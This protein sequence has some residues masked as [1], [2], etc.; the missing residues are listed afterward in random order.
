VV[1]PNGTSSVT[2]LLVPESFRRQG[3][4]RSL[5]E[6][7]QELYPNLGGQVSSKYAAKSAYDLGRRPPDNPKASLEEVFNA[8]D[9]DSS[10]NLVS[11]NQEKLFMPASEAGAGKGKQAEAAKLWNEK[12]TDSPYFKKWFG[13]SKVVDDNGEPLVVYHGTKGRFNEFE[14]SRGGEFGSGMY[15]S[16]NIDSAKMFGGFQAGD[17]EVVTMPAYLTLKNP[18]ITSDRNIP[19]GAGVKSL[20]KKGYDGVIGTTPN[21]QKQ[22]IAFSPEQ[23][24]SATGNRGTFDAG[25]R[26]ILFMPA[27]EAK[28]PKSGDMLTLDDKSLKLFLPSP[29][30]PNASLSE[31]KGKNVQ[32][33]TADLSVVGDKKADGVM[34]SFTGGPGYLSVNDAWGFTNEGGAKAFKTRWE[35]DGK[36]LIG[37]TSM[38]QEN[39][40]AST[41][42]REYYVR[43]FMEAINDGKI[44][45]NTVNRHIKTALKRAIDGKNGLTNN[46]KAALKTV[47]TI[48]DFL[49]V[50]PDK[51]LIPWK[52][53]PM[54]YGKLDAKTLPIKQDRLKKLGLDTETI[55]RETRQPEY[56]DI[57]KGSLLAIAEYDGSGATYRPDLNSAYPW[58]IPLNEKAFLKDFADIQD[59]SSRPDLRGSD[60]EANMAVAMGAGVMLDKLGRGDVNFMPSDP[61]APKAQPANR[62]QQQAPAMPGNRFMAPAASAGAKLSE[63]FR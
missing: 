6:K 8:I 58:S 7:A 39:H 18:L 19:R 16:E 29:S 4:G 31:F 40:R 53:T 56:N 34:I 59:L 61:K 43:K 10:V 47:K 12:G 57:K 20:I 28:N 5:Q 60:G 50:F 1:K 63:R 54:I 35:R 32:V 3:I 17:S 33:L 37:I 9:Q 21:G 26:N 52:A 2:Q 22:Y 62:I 42:T 49:K 30:N 13:K 23:I 24:K 38:K 11:Q 36:P 25:E 46:Q 51:E 15:F 45:E 55:L 14:R 44:S 27:S 48:E 41:L